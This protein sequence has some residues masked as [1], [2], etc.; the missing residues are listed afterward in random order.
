MNS[1]QVPAKFPIAFASSADPSHIQQVPTNYNPAIPGSFGLDVGSPP[2]TFLA[3]GAGGTPPLGEYFNGLMNQVT[4]CIRWIQAGGYFQY[5]ATFQ[6]A[7]GGYFKGA[8]V[9]SA[10]YGAF[11][12]STVE[13]NMT[14]PDTG[15][16]TAPA[17]GWAVLQPGTYP[18][19]QITGAPSFVQHSEFSSQLVGVNGYQDTPDGFRNQWMEIPVASASNTLVTVAYPIAFPT[20]SY[21]PRA[22]VFDATLNAGSSSNFLQA[23]VISNSL[24]GCQVVLG[25]NG[26]GARNVTLCIDVRG[27]SA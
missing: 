24:S 25:Q 9:K 7:I 1:S 22:T 26:G 21:K 14:N 15:T 23:T 4:A 11:W 27:R 5:D 20:T 10:A 3:P 17:T 16:L 13:N 12:T 19:G 6:A 8:I 18:W 2:E